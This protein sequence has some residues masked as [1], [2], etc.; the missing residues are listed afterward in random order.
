M[1]APLGIGVVGCGSVLAVY[2]P[3]IERLDYRGLARLVMAC[4]RDE[5]KRSLMAEQYHVQAFTLEYRELVDPRKWSR[6]MCASALSS[7]V[8]L[9]Q[10]CPVGQYCASFSSQIS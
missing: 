8:R 3:L 2:A 10:Y 4:D 6:F 9:C 7:P 5:A 1:H